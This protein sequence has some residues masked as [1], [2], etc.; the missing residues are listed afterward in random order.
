MVTVHLAHNYSFS[1]ASHKGLATH[2]TALRR[3]SCCCVASSSAQRIV[4]QEQQAKRSGLNIIKC[5]RMQQGPFK[6]FSCSILTRPTYWKAGWVPLEM[7]QVGPGW[8]TGAFAWLSQMASAFSF[9]LYS[10]LSS[11]WPQT[12]N[13][14]STWIITALLLCWHGHATAVRL[15]MLLW[16]KV[17]VCLCL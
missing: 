5:D 12:P 17:N 10:C 4:G 14:S 7:F 3:Q 8:G 15:L 6:S 2:L 13:L 9:M 1:Q 16:F 11:S